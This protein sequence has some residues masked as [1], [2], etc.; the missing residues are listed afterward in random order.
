MSPER[1][2]VI[3]LRLKQ[4]DPKKAT[5]AKLLRLGLAEKY[6]FNRGFSLLVLNPY[7]RALIS[8]MDR[9]AT[10][11]VVAV[12]A[13]WRRIDEVKWPRGRQRRLPFLVAANP[14]NYGMP[15]KLSTVEAIAAAL[16]ILGFKE[17]AFEMLRPFK[18]GY[19]FLSL[20]RD[21][22]ESYSMFS[23]EEDVKKLDEKFRKELYG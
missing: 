2:K 19:G 22:L 9:E 23:S 4:D 10:K 8:P 7:A 6:R 12:D 15:E 16:Y 1:V 11:G 17:Q 20:N 14:I 18:W 21:R 13:S 3:I 5:G